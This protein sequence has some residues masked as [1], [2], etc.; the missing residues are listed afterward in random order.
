MSWPDRQ[1]PLIVAHA[2]VP[3]IMGTVLFATLCIVLAN[4]AVDHLRRRTAHPVLTPAAHGAL[5]PA[6]AGP[7]SLLAARTS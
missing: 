1:W 6:G 4:L 7:P 2:D 3:L 5:G